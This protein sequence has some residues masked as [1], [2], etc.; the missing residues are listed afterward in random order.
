MVDVYIIV[1]ECQPKVGS[2]GELGQPLRSVL[3]RLSRAHVDVLDIVGAEKALC[4]LHVLR[5]VYSCHVLSP[6]PELRVRAAP[7]DLNGLAS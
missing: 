7:L 5:L 2:V 3:G 6:S 1:V 4:L